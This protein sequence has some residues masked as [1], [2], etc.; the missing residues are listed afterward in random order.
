MGGTF[1]KKGVKKNI[2]GTNTEKII[3]VIA[4]G[5]G[6]TQGV[7]HKSKNPEEI[8]SYNGIMPEWFAK[9]VKAT[10]LAPTALNKQVSTIKGD[11]HK[12]S[13]TCNNGVFS[14]VDLGI[15]KYHFEIAAGKENF[16]W[17]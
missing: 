3:G 17:V 9:G 8:S 13:M 16:E 14:G 15:R 2:S 4:I 11:N 10:L 7:P 6:I 5:Y 12:V 1:R